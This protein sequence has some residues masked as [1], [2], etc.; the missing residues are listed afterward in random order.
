M[1]TDHNNGFPDVKIKVDKPKTSD[2]A[3]EFPL[4]NL[5]NTPK[6][7]EATLNFH[8]LD[9]QGNTIES[10]KNFQSSNKST[11]ATYN[12][13][14]NVSEFVSES[15]WDAGKDKVFDYN[16]TINQEFFDAS[17]NSTGEDTTYYSG[18]YQPNPN[19]GYQGNPNNTIQ[20]LD[21]APANTLEKGFFSRLLQFF[22]R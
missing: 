10:T 4:S 20:V 9:S 15:N 7:F 6:I 19:S 14:F 16:L 11:S 21:H 8:H 1:P 2:P 18:T 12:M 22:R 5:L 17:G 13:I 3:F